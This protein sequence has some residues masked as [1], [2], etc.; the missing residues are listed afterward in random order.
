MSRAKF[1]LLEAEVKFNINYNDYSSA[2]DI[3]AAPGGWTSLLLEKG[4][5]VTAID[6]SNL[7]PDLLRN[8]NLT[9][10]KKRLMKFPYRNISMIC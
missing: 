2:L 3:G 7:H 5:K 1:K 4:L 9:F 10:Y 8:P 6:P